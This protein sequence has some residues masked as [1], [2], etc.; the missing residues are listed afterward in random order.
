MHEENRESCDIKVEV[1]EHFE[2]VIVLLKDHIYLPIWEIP[3]FFLVLACSYSSENCGH[4]PVSL[5]SSPTVTVSVPIP[6]P[7]F[8]FLSLLTLTIKML[9]WGPCSNV[10]PWSPPW[11][12]ESH[13]QLGV[14]TWNSQP[15]FELIMFESKVFLFV[16]YIFGT[17]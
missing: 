12:P 15:R 5:K 1:I 6:P 17:I 14:S 4:P 8:F 3:S 9:S 10:Q 16:S 13:F 2:L 7:W 11:T